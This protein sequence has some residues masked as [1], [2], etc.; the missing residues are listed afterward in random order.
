MSAYR[1]PVWTT[2]ER[3]AKARRDAGLSQ[4][5]M[6]ALLTTPDRPVSKQTVSNWEKGVNQPRQFQQVLDQWAE[7]THVS[8]LWL[9]GFEDAATLPTDTR[10]GS[11][12]ER[13]LI[14]AAA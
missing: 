8:V 7:V 5:E 1:V 2:G 9:L 14:G 11:S 12:V 4:A 6:A 10:S 3:M 13:V